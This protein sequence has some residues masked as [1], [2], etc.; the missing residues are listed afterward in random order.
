M[1][2]ERARI[3]IKDARVEVGQEHALPSADAHHL[4]NVL[5]LKAGDRLTVISDQSG[6]R[7]NAEI[8]N[9][10]GQLAV[11]IL[12]KA[13]ETQARSCVKVLAFALLKGA[14]NDQIVRQSAELGVD[15][16]IAFQA[17]RSLVKIKSAGDASGKID[18]WQK[19]IESASRQAQQTQI[20]RLQVA[21]SMA[22]AVE[23]INEICSPEDLLL[24]GALLPGTQ[25]L[26]KLQAPQAQVALVVGPEGDLSPQ[27][28]ALLQERGYQ[29][30]SMG[31][32][33]L[34]AET[35]SICAIASAH[36]LWGFKL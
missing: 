30:F 33:R 34:R 26:R 1:T 31:P 36:A 17:E 2:A 7:F 10:K 4:T 18:R 3:F 14:H 5:R 21:P 13:A 16:L 24:F 32:M 22:K 28:I 27:E 9:G 6:E 19:I 23:L 25:E 8:Q 20:S 11:K 15:Q 12:E 35:A 29:A